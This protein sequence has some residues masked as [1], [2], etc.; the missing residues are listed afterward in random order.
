MST[1]S[2]AGALGN[3]AHSIADVLREKIVAAGGNPG[4]SFAIADLVKKLPSGNTIIET[5]A[6]STFSQQDF[7]SML[8]TLVEYH[9]GMENVLAEISKSRIAEVVSDNETLVR[10]WGFA[11][12]SMRND[13]GQ[14][15][16]PAAIE[17]TFDEDSFESCNVYFGMG[18]KVASLAAGIH[19]SMDDVTSLLG[20]VLYMKGVTESA[21]V[22]SDFTPLD[23]MVTG[24]QFR[25]F[26]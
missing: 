19:Q 4:N 5:V 7:I 10:L 14:I 11:S 13:S 24:V 25:F 23:S 8:H 22:L 9:G 21:M 12:V 15:T 3:D 6:T 18:T 26:Y 16:L 2:I 17:S 20:G 1:T